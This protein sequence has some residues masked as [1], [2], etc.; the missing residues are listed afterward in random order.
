MFPETTELPL[1]GY[2][3]ES[4][5]TQ[6]FKSS[7]ST[8]KTNSQTYWS[9]EISHVM[10]GIIFCVCSTLAISVL[11]FVLKWCRKE[12]K[13][14]SGE[15]RVTAKSRPMMNSVI[16][17]MTKPWR[18][19]MKVRVPGVRKLRN[20]MERWNPL[21]AV[22]QVTRQGTTT[23]SLK[24][25]TQQATQDGMMTKLGLLKSGNLMNWW[26]IERRN[27]LFALNE[28]QGHSNSSLETTKQNWICR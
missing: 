14:E 27:P 19:V 6:K 9:R 28:E 1:I 7:T 20:M 16:L 5:W 23:D 8:P 3:I 26:T 17:G 25:R 15:E 4:F 13:K 10:N 12:R 22:T 18:K 2:S 11:Q 24:A 21:L